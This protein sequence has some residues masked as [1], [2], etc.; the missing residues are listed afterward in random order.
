MTACRDCGATFT[1]DQAHC[2]MPRC[3][4]TFTG[5]AAYDAHWVGRRCAPPGANPALTQRPDG[6]WKLTAIP[7]QLQLSFAGRR[8]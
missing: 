8:R 5:P 4:Q 6:V 1:G 7:G 3:H 2:T